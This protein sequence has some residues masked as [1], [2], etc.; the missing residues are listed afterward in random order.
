MV[1]IQFVTIIHQIVVSNRA[2]QPN[3]EISC[4]NCPFGQK[5]AFIPSND[6]FKQEII[7]LHSDW[8]LWLLR[9]PDQREIQKII[10]LSDRFTGNRRVG[11]QNGRPVYQEMM[12]KKL[13]NEC[14]VTWCT[15]S[16]LAAILT[17][18]ITI[19]CTMILVRSITSDR[20]HSTN[21]F[22]TCKNQGD[23]CPNFWTKWFLTTGMVMW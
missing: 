1:A 4:N 7:L 16:V 15:S 17:Q 6:W 8:F 2:K 22:Q 9:T 10:S 11:Y 18:L 13:T 3:L 21:S 23:N 12:V 14:G 20:E 5:S 19:P